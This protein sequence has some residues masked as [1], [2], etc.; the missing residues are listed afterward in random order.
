MRWKPFAKLVSCRSTSSCSVDGFRLPAP[1]PSI[2]VGP[3][4]AHGAGLQPAHYCW[5]GTP[6]PGEPDASSRNGSDGAISG[7]HTIIM[8]SELRASV[9]QSE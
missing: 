7:S 6:P 8:P 2:V 3:G 5:M 4:S 9:S 1:L